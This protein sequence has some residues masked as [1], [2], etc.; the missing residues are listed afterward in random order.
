MQADVR[1]PD[2]SWKSLAPRAAA[3]AAVF[4]AFAAYHLVNVPR[5]PLHDF[6]LPFDWGIPIIPAFSVPY[7]L[8]LPYLFFTVSYGILATAEWKRI[9]ASV[10]IVQVVACAVYLLY[11][12]HVPRPA[13]PDDA[14]FGWLLR[15][16]YA[17]DQ[18][19]NTFPSLH[20]AQSLV[21][22]YWWRRLDV[23]WFPAVGTLTVLILIATVVLK[24]H[25]VLDVAAGALLSLGALYAVERLMPRQRPRKAMASLYDL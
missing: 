8:Y 25:V 9:A 21:C 23:R 13:V 14:L 10:L 2:I 20:V 11:Q 16:I 22:L 15:F 12:T 3:L 7:L 6:A 18:P 24:Q 5:F 17:H 1:L 19:Y 4:A